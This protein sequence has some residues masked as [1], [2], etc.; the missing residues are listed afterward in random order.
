MS[1]FVLL[2]PRGDVAVLEPSGDEAEEAAMIMEENGGVRLNQNVEEAER[3]SIRKALE[4]CNGRKGMAA[5]ALG[6]SR[7]TLFRKMKRLEMS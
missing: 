2:V 5:K 7:K 3:A 1:F 4:L 6:I